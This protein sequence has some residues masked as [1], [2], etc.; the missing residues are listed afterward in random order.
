MDEI[1]LEEPTGKFILDNLPFEKRFQ[2]AN[3]LYIH[4]A[5][6]CTL[7]KK[8]HETNVKKLNKVDVIAQSDNLVNFLLHLNGKGLIN[9]HDFDY[10]KEAKKYC[11]KIK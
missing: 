8:Y 11:E 2:T 10:E 1:E 5:D 4:Y 3:G 6:V 7:L 9:N